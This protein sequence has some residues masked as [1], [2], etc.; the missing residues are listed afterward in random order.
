MNYTCLIVC[1][2][3]QI[4]ANIRAKDIKFAMTLVYNMQI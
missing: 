2:N 1:M 4:S 3:S